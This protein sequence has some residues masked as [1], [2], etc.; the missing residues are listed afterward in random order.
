[1]KKTQPE[2]L[3]CFSY[4]KD[5]NCQKSMNKSEHVACVSVQ[6]S[7][8]PQK[9]SSMRQCWEIQKKRWNMNQRGYWIIPC[10]PTFEIDFQKI[11]WT[12]AIWPFSNGW[13]AATGARRSPPGSSLVSAF[14]RESWGELRWIHRMPSLDSPEDHRMTTEWPHCIPSGNLLHSYWKWS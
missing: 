3:G 13:P 14:Q 7:L 9:A 5:S 11:R 2:S 8:Q 10:V 6:C 12:V 4:L 1:M